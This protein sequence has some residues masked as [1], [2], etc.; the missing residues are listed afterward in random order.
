MWGKTNNDAAYA[1]EPAPETI[2]DYEKLASSYLKLLEEWKIASDWSRVDTG[3]PDV[4]LQERA[5]PGYEIPMMKLEGVLSASVDEV[6]GLL[7]SEKL[8]E[9]RLYDDFMKHL[10]IV[11]R[12]TP[13][14]VVAYVQYKAVFP[15]SDRDFVAFRAQEK[16]PDGTRISYGHTI[17]YSKRPITPNCVRAKGKLATYCIPIPG[18]YYKTKIIRFLLL[19]PMGTIPK[20]VVN[21]AKAVAGIQFQKIV[22]ALKRK[23]GDARPPPIAATLTTEGVGVISETESDEEFFETEDSLLDDYP[24]STAVQLRKSESDERAMVIIGEL[25]QAI[26]SLNSRV[27]VLERNHTNFRWISLGKRGVF[28]PWGI[29]IS[30]LLGWPVATVVIYHYLTKPKKFL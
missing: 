1:D 2:E 22:K 28:I 17:K 8:E 25:K 3:N 30:F 26:Q 7:E 10:E 11:D 24:S 12:I 6:F 4:L 14:I 20:W 5:V 16:L 18:E 23:Y 9:R 27:D 29:F 19:D 13:K 15:V 21:K